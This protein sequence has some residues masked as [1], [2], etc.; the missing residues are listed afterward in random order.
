MV[1]C[2]NFY[3]AQAISND[4]PD[5]YNS[6]YE[7]N[8]D[9]KRNVAACY[10]STAFETNDQLLEKADLNNA[11]EIYLPIDA[12]AF[13]IDKKYAWLESFDGQP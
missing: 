5:Y 2:C 9:I 7:A 13:N 11:Q 12:E 10:F 3:S 1:G 8:K 4:Q 6:E